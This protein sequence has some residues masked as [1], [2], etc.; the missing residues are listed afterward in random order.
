MLDKAIPL[1]PWILEL[2]AIAHADQIRG[3][4]TALA[5]HMRHDIAPE[6][7]RGRVAVQEDDRAPL[8]QLDIG[9]PLALD[10]DELLFRLGG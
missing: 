8:A 3:Q 1:R 4:A 10:L 9:H 5:L 6:I 2:V 7:G